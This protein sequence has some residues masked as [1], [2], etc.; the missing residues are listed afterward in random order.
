MKKFP[1]VF[2]GMLFNVIC[3]N[4]LDVFSVNY[5]DMTCINLIIFSQSWSVHINHIEQFF[6]NLYNEDFKLKFSKC[7][8]TLPS[9]IYFIPVSL[10]A[11]NLIT[12]Q[13]FRQP[14]TK[15]VVHS[16]LESINFIHQYTENSARIFKLFHYL[17]CKKRSFQLDGKLW[18]SI[19]LIKTLLCS[20]PILALFEPKEP[21]VE[22]DTSYKSIWGTLK[23]PDENCFL[24]PVF[25]F[26]RKPSNREKKMSSL[27]YRLLYAAIMNLVKTSQQNP[28]LMKYWKNSS[29]TYLNLPSILYTKI[30][31]GKISSQIS[32]LSCISCNILNMKM[33][34]KQ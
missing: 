15:F 25:Y 3:R 13:T 14:T 2:Q 7:K 19:K 18:R 1:A 22:T 28:G 21:M 4:S 11:D 9:V 32:S 20:S 23:Q 17:T 30:R 34:F 16:V 31:K 5:I 8:L 33:L 24:H 27:T 29:I 12:I 6:R 10:A 26:S